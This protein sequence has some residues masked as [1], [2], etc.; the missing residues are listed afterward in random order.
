MPGQRGV[1]RPKISQ[2]SHNDRRLDETYFQ[3]RRKNTVENLGIKIIH[4]KS[5]IKSCY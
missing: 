2:L 1:S 4:V 3:Q 5:L